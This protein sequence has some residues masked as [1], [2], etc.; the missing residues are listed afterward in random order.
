[1]RNEPSR[2]LRQAKVELREPANVK[3]ENM[4]EESKGESG[5]SKRKAFHSIVTRN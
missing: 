2:R 3:Q 1:M 5:F 4:N